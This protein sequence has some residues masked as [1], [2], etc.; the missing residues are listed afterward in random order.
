MSKKVSTF[1]KKLSLEEA[2]K[3]KQK[4]TPLGEAL[5]E[6]DKEYEIRRVKREEVP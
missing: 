1:S 6:A 5:Q 4:G 2:E 3:E